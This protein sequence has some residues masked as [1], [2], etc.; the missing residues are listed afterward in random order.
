M[1]NLFNKIFF[2]TLLVL[3]GCSKSDEQSTELVDNSP[4]VNSIQVFVSSDEIIVGTSIL[5]SVFDNTGKNRT[6]EAKF[7]VDN[8]EISGSSHTFNDVGT[9][10]VY[11]KYQNIKTFFFSMIF[12]PPRPVC[13]LA[14]YR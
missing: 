11:A 14:P 12:W 5:F 9:F 6:N 13:I 4:T 7:F 1:R 2:V 3:V 10:E 8:T